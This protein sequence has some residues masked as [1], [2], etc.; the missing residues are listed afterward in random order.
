[1]AFHGVFRRSSDGTL[2][3]MP[4]D[5]SVPADINS[6]TCDCTLQLLS[7]GRFVA[8]PGDNAG[9]NSATCKVTSITGTTDANYIASLLNTVAA[10]P[11]PLAP[12]ARW[13]V[14]LSALQAASAGSRIVLTQL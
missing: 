9:V 8:V 5:G 11:T 3:I 4:N 2:R 13:S 1:M 7:D 10:I 6:L 14:S 12:T